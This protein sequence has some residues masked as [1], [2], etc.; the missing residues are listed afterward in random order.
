MFGRSTSK[1]LGVLAWLWVSVL[2]TVG[3]VGGLVVSRVGWSLAMMLAIYGG[4]TEPVRPELPYP[5]LFFALAVIAGAG[6][7]IW[8][9]RVRQRPDDDKEG[10]GL[11]N[12]APFVLAYAG[13]L[14]SAVL[15]FIQ[16]YRL[17]STV[18]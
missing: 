7:L 3:A 6:G 4:N 11:A 2:L 13:G 5:W 15:P 1:K 9:L 18:S 17:W 14:F 12:V 8:A 16:L 10:M